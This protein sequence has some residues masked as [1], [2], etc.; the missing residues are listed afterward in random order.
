M[1][2]I[3]LDH[4]AR[5]IPGLRIVGAHLGNPWSD[6][7]AMACRW[8]PNLFFDLSGSLL[9]YRKPD[10]LGGLL[11][12][13]ASGPYKSPDGTSAWQKIVFGSDVAP[14]E[15]ADVIHDYEVLMDA[16]NLDADLR[17]QIWG[18]T[19]MKVLGL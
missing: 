3:H 2:P 10:Y 15:V 6:E 1:R 5:T 12:W 16:L 7:A 8:N 19:A 9:K 14:D 17:Q 13:K 11:W 4:I 18:G